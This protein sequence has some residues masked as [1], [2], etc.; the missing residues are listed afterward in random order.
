MKEDHRNTILVTGAS[1]GIGRAVAIELARQGYDIAVHY[2]RDERGAAA[3][4]EEIQSN[5]ANGRLLCFDVS[6]R[7]HSAQVLA[8]DIEQFGAYYGVVCNAGITR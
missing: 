5:E 3:T 6:D 4:L 7:E 8:S 1:R 2:V